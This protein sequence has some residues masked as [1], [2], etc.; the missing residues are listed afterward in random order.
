[1]IVYGYE[2]RLSFVSRVRIHELY[3]RVLPD[4]L[5]RSSALEAALTTGSLEP[6][7]GQISATVKCSTT[8]WGWG[9]PN[10]IAGSAT[11]EGK[12]AAPPHLSRSRRRRTCRILLEWQD[13]NTT[14]NGPCDAMP[15]AM[16]RCGHDFPGRIGGSTRP[17]SSLTPLVALCVVL[18]LWITP[19]DEGEDHPLATTS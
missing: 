15:V 8:E 4:R 16:S 2:Y 1:M 10:N 19:N 5:L 11:C 18:S 12:A 14:T 9:I 6:R 3:I 13:N 7:P 17:S